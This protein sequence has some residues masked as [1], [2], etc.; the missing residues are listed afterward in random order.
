MKIR[1]IY[2]MY[3]IRVSWCY[4]SIIITF[5]VILFWCHKGIFWGEKKGKRNIENC[6]CLW[7][8]R[9][10]LTFAQYI[11][12]N[13]LSF[14]LWIEMFSK[15]AGKMQKFQHEK[16]SRVFHVIFCR[17]PMI[18]WSFNIGFVNGFQFLPIGPTPSAVR[19]FRSSCQFNCQLVPIVVV[20]LW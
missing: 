5:L 17:C 20:F 6:F 3:I 13:I 2:I 16:L 14:S 10:L 7:R 8:I 15:H 12:L 11:D 1:T 18:V 19:P 9:S 4:F